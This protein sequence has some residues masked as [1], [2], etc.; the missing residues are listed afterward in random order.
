MSAH[1]EALDQVCELLGRLPDVV[2][3]RRRLID[4]SAQ[5]DVC[6]GKATTMDSLQHD[7]MSANVGMDHW[8]R[9]SGM[10][11]VA[12]P[13]HRIITASASPMKGLDFGYL[14]ILGIHLIWRLHRLGLLTA[15]Q[16]NP[17]LRAWNAVEVCD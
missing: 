17:R 16:A 10:A 3:L 8:L 4:S 5:I 7:V 11:T 13:V 1:D 2:V 6:I 9:S 12:F 14:Q 15:A